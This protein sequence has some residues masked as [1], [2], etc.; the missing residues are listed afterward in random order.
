MVI[1]APAGGIILDVLVCDWGIPDPVEEDRPPP[2]RD[3]TADA[4]CAILQAKLGISQINPHIPN[5]E[6]IYYIRSMRVFF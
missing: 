6:F 4:G 3:E 2:F 5:E 1:A